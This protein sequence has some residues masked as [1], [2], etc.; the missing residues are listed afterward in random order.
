[1]MCICTSLTASAISF[2]PVEFTQSGAPV[3]NPAITGSVDATVT[4]AS[5]A[6]GEKLL[7]TA[8]S[9]DAQG[10]LI[11]VNSTYIN[12]AS[13]S[14]YATIPVTISTANTKVIVNVFACDDT[15][16]KLTPVMK[17]A[18]M[19]SDS[20]DMSYITINGTKINIDNANVDKDYSVHLD[21]ATAVNYEY[22]AKDATTVVSVDTPAKYDV[23]GGAYLRFDVT[24]ADGTVRR[25]YVKATADTAPAFTQNSNLI[26][27][28]EA[29]DNTGRNKMDTTTTDWLD[30]NN[31]TTTVDVA[32]ATNAAE[33]KWDAEKGAFIPPY[34]QDLV[35]LPDAVKD[36]LNNVLNDVKNNATTKRSATIRFELAEPATGTM[37]G[38]NIL[39]SEDGYFQIYYATTTGVRCKFAAAT[40][41]SNYIQLTPAQVYSG[42]NTIIFSGPD[43]KIYWYVDD[44]KVGEATIRTGRNAKAIGDEKAVTFG[45][46][47]ASASGRLRIKSLEV[48]NTAVTP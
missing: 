13:N 25:I 33:G 30:V 22:I 18:T 36:A 16:K 31:W 43:G 2:E 21:D 12:S 38:A 35:E 44:Q 5:G 14:S 29:D 3:T 46:S 15:T 47:G 17:N 48:Y 42:V 28:L 9:Y 20:T 10:R 32:K 24:A 8:G 19:A 41:S 11:G 1:M 39:S 40:S 6:A 4:V 26:L 45:K 34:G 7:V 27:K 37:S 23:A